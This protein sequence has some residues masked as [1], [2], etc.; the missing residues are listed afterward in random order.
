MGYSPNKKAWVL[1]VC[2]A[3]GVILCS[4]IAHALPG[5]T[6]VLL[7]TLATKDTHSDFFALLT[8]KQ[9]VYHITQVLLKHRH[10]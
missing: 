3:V 8:G 7:D 5:D 9:Q 4:N 1:L 10:R 6:L 2:G